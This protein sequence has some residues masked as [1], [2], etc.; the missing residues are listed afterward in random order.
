M[1]EG[2]VTILEGRTGSSPNPGNND[3]TDDRY[4]LR[5]MDGDDRGGLTGL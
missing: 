2:H 5:E 4:D 1:V 3:N